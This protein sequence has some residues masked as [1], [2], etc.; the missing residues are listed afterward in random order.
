M[1]LPLQPY[2]LPDIRLL[3]TEI[4]PA[5]LVWQPDEVYIILGRSNAPERSVFRERALEDGAVIMK[6]PSGGETVVLTPRTLVVAMAWPLDF[7][8]SQSEVFRTCNTLIM[9]TLNQMGV[10]GLKQM[11]IS[12]ISHG[13]RKIAGSAMHKAR[14]R[15]F[16]HAVLNVG[17]PAGTFAWYLQIGRAHV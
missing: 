11:G 5:G 13:D 8:S 17:E 16:F 15:W 14:D 4:L 3:S 9:N 7:S 6:R 12:D 10:V 2:T 1:N